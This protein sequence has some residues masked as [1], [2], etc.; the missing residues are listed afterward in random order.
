M[1]KQQ[2]ADVGVEQQGESRRW[3]LS[4][5]KSNRVQ[6]HPGKGEFEA[7]A[8]RPQRAN[9]FSNEAELLKSFLKSE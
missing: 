8:G 3:R 4:S 6:T 5:V 1:V 2:P 7:G 9:T